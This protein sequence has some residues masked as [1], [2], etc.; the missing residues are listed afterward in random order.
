MGFLPDIRQELLQLRFL[1]SAD[2]FDDVFHVRKEIQI[3]QLCRVH[4][5]RQNRSRLAALGTTHIVDYE[6]TYCERF[7]LANTK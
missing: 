5:A 4:Q 2:P 3:V 1:H 7:I 6:R